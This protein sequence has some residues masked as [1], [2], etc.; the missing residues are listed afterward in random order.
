MIGAR[1]VIVADE[2]PHIGRMMVPVQNVIFLVKLILFPI[3]FSGFVICWCTS[4]RV[5]IYFYT[6]AVYIN[7]E[8]NFVMPWTLL[9][10]T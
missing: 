1:H 7:G 8:N 9:V 5:V 2:K 10:G 6:V 4:V 3:G